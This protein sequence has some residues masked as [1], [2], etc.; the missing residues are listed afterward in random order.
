MSGFNRASNSS[1]QMVRAA[2]PL[3]FCETKLKK[4]QHMLD[5]FGEIVKRRI[6]L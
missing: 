5:D 3:N 2:Y 4:P 6:L 1:A